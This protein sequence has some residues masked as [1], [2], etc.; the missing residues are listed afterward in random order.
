LYEF[1]RETEQH[2]INLGR[3]RAAQAPLET[4]SLRLPQAIAGDLL[5]AGDEFRLEVPAAGRQ[6]LDSV[7]LRAEGGTRVGALA[8]CAAEGAKSSLEV[9]R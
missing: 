8:R 6:S 5:T 3:I 4:V 7:P 1:D 9:K 2:P